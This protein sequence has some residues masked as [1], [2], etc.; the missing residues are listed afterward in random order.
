MCMERK[1]SWKQT[2]QTFCLSH[3][4]QT[5]QIF[6]SCLINQLWALGLLLVRGPAKS[7]TTPRRAVM[8]LSV[9]LNSCQSQSGAKREHLFPQRKSPQ[10]CSAQNS[11]CFFFFLVLYL[12][13]FFWGVDGSWQESPPAFVG[14]Q[15]RL[16]GCTRLWKT[17]RLEL[18]KM[19]KWDS[20]PQRYGSKVSFRHARKKRHVVGITRSSSDSE[21][22]DGEAT[23]SSAAPWYFCTSIPA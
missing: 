1:N 21:A 7:I 12:W 11:S 20:Q 19:D 10:R 13:G 23:E 22:T 3:S 4:K 2:G 15:R 6:F 8:C 9:L 14:T 17:A 16:I 18:L 5:N